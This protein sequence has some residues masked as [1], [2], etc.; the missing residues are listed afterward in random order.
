MKEWNLSV[1]LVDR[2]IFNLTHNLSFL[3]GVNK[4]KLTA[5]FLLAVSLIGGK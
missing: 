1:E 4:P 5:L 2:I 3:S